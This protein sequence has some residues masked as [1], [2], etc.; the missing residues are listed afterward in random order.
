MA[1]V[2]PDWL[3]PQEFST[4]IDEMANAIGQQWVIHDGDPKLRSYR[5]SFSTLPG[6]ANVP[7][8]V[9]APDGIEEIQAILKIANDHRVPLWP[10]STG[11]NFAYG[12]PA[13][14]MPGYVVLDLKRMNRILE[15]NEEYAYALVEPGVSY[16]QLYEYLQKNNI[17]LWID[18]AAPGWGGIVGNTLEHGVGYTPY[19]DHFMMHCGMEVVLPDGT[20]FRTGQGSLPETE[21]WQVFQYGFGPILDGV[22][23]QSNFGIVT[24]MGMWLMPE[25]PGY[26]PFLITYENEEDLAI[27]T[28]VVRPLKVNMVIPNGAFTVDLLWDAAVKVSKRQYYSGKGPIPDSARKKI[29]SDYKLG[30][31]NFYAALYGP[32]PMM[33]NTMQ[34]IRDTLGAIPGARVWTAEERK[35]DAAFQYRSKL[36]RGEPNM[37]EFGLMNWVGGGGHI[38]FSPISPT[39]GEDAMRQYEMIKNRSHEYGFDYIGEFAVGWRDMHHVYMLMFDRTDDEERQRAHE[40]FGVLI[41]EAAAAGYGEYR[42]HLAFMDQ[43]AKTYSWNDHALW[44]LHERLK[45]AFDPNGIL[46]PGKQGIWPAHMREKHSWTS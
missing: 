41:D 25:P 11:R 36:M 39:T 3:S 42:T 13:P 28:E 26:M 2:L 38:N 40:L 24:K 8:A 21:S 46:A 18:P 35:H 44:K 6:D 17:K 43:V 5:D 34:V 20:L 9:V 10:I 29:M 19:G 31:W 7:S 12:G 27:I 16:F 1:A 37:T 30:Q 32:P 4:A 14:R 22:F 45:D 15:V 33:E 23:S